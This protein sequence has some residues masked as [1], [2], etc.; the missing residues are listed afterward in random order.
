MELDVLLTDGNN[1][2]TYA[3]LRALVE[4][5]LKIGII[6]HT[7]LSLSFYSK[8]PIRKFKVNKNIMKDEDMYMTELMHI[9][10]K[11]RINVILPVS[12]ISYH[13]MAKHQDEILKHVKLLIVKNE[14]MQIAQNKNMTFEFAQKKGILIPQTFILTN[15]HEITQIINEI[16]FPCVIKKTN[17]DESGVIYCNNEKELKHEY[18]TYVGKLKKDESLP[19]IQEYIEGKGVGFYGLFDNGKCIAT[20]THERIHEFPI[21]GG[22]STF[23]KSNKN[24]ELEKVGI[25]VLEELKWNG[26]A[27]VE[28]KRDRNNNYYLIEINP[29]F[30]GSLELSYVAGINF[31]YLV[32]QLLNN[33]I[34]SD[35]SYRDNIYFRWIF[36]HD[37]LWYWFA[38]KKQKKE[39]RTL[40]KE[41][42]IY[43]NIHWD[44]PLTILYNI[45]FTGF[46]LIKERRYPH[47]KIVK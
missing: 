24:P 42:I 31:P 32:Y 11:N 44:D 27:M 16:K 35:I 21:T 6:F 38:T 28:F 17:F 34:I 8:Y 1:K 3:I 2:H 47:G 30:W 7:K 39:S 4:K 9:L 25:K 45:L 22:A 15:R 33:Q 18:N 14:I 29:K 20:F 5:K 26:I 13:F 10:R 46:K 12:N 40:G 36:P 37:F 19:V 41:C 43:N 23:A